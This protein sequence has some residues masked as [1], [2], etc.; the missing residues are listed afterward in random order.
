MMFNVCKIRKEVGKACLSWCHNYFIKVS[1]KSKE[2]QHEISATKNI[3]C[4]LHSLNSSL[5]KT[6][7]IPG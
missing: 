2:D 6:T 4:E 7:P 3:S 1:K 5:L